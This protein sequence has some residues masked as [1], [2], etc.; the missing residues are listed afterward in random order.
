MHL[1]FWRMALNSL[2]FCMLS[3]SIWRWK[4]EDSTRDLNWLWR[5][6]CSR[7]FFFR[8]LIYECDFFWCELDDDVKAWEGPWLLRIRA[9]LASISEASSSGLCWWKRELPS[10]LEFSALDLIL[11]Y[12]SL[13]LSSLKTSAK[14]WEFISSLLSGALKLCS[15]WLN[16]G[17]YLFVEV[18]ELI[19]SFSPWDP[20]EKPCPAALKALAFWI[21]SLATFWKS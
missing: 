19:I 2:A 20:V 21:C 10:C 7:S 6:T 3:N 8:R 9:L 17:R 1:I 13:S 18:P 14:S 11:V 4:G 12:G 15:C 16:E 5:W